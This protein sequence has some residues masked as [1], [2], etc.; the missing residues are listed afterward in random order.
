MKN[1]VKPTIDEKGIKQ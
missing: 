1:K